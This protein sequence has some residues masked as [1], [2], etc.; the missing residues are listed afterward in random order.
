M[1][2]APMASILATTFDQQIAASNLQ[3][4]MSP[5]SPSLGEKVANWPEE[6]IF[7]D[8]SVRSAPADGVAGQH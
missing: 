1:S 8:D 7:E 2:E 3:C 5:F 4:S 6:V